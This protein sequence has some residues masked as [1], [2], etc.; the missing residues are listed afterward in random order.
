MR[1]DKHTPDIAKVR[2][3]GPYLTAAQVVPLL[4]LKDEMLSELRLLEWVGDVRYDSFQ[5]RWIGHC[6]RCGRPSTASHR[7]DC[8]LSALIAKAEGNVR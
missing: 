2:E 5:D 1:D 4:E 3:Y 7:D 8:R 6:P